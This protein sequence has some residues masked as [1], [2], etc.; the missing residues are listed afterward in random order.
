MVIFYILAAWLIIEITLRRLLH[1]K[2]K[3]IFGKYE[4]VSQ[5][6]ELIEKYILL[7]FLVV[8]TLDLFIGLLKTSF[9]L[10]WLY[11]MAL[12]VNRGFQEWSYDRK[13]KEYI[14]NWLGSAISVIIFVYYLL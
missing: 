8:L 13:N 7:I 3:G 9:S 4:H 6:H 5:K 1:V 2:Q 14:F 12:F 11:L 10:T